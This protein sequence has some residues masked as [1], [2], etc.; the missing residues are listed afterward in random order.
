MSQY[1]DD[2]IRLALDYDEYRA[3]ELE[4]LGSL[5]GDRQRYMARYFESL[6]ENDTPRVRASKSNPLGLSDRGHT[7]SVWVDANGRRY[8]IYTMENSHLLNIISYLRRRA[9][10]KVP[11]LHSV[12]AIDNM[13]QEHVITY[14]AMLQEC[15]KRKLVIPRDAHLFGSDTRDEVLDSKGTGYLSQRLEKIEAGLKAREQNRAKLAERIAKLESTV[16]PL[17][18]SVNDLSAQIDAFFDVIEQ[19]LEKLEKELLN[20]RVQK[21]TRPASKRK[22]KKAQR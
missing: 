8:P 20:L 7:R 21:I 5:E 2:G 18:V 10:T 22:T 17:D 12:E 19:R 3:M 13:L 15:E 6:M 11:A 14:D 1:D 4:D 9:K 16:K